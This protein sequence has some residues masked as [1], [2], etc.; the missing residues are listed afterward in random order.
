VPNLQ[1]LRSDFDWYISPTDQR[2]YEHIYTAN[3]DR[4]GQI[5]LSSLADFYSTIDVPDTDIRR[6]WDL[7]NPKQTEYINKDATMYFLHILNNRHDGVRVPR[8]IPAS[9]RATMNRKEIEYDVSKVQVR[10]KRDDDVSVRRTTEREDWNSTTSSKKNDFAAGYLSRL[11]VGEG[12]SKYNSTGTTLP[13]LSN[14]RI[15]LT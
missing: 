7:V 2:T 3:H 11:G 4:H 12:S 6:A 8:S 15:R 13:P 1:G 5:S 10:G 14:F 9:L